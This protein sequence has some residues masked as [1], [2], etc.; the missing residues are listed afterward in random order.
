MKKLSEIIDRALGRF[1][2]MSSKDREEFQQAQRERFQRATD[3][4]DPEWF[5]VGGAHSMGSLSLV[6][7]ASMD[8]AAEDSMGVDEECGSSDKYTLVEDADM[9]MLYSAN[10]DTPFAA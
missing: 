5:V 6:T 7:D 1:D 3:R 8:Y 4:L 9:T 10:D 2:Q